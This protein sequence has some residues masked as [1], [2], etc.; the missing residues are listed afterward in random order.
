ML[1]ILDWINSNFWN[2]N[3]RVPFI[4]DGLIST[5]IVDSSQIN[6]RNVLSGVNILEVGCGGGILTEAL[7]KLNA[8]IVALEPSQKLID[9]ATKHLQDTNFQN[10]KIQY[11]CETVESH[12]ESNKDKYDAVV[13]SEVLEHI[14]D[15]KS[16]LKSS[17]E[18]LKP[19]GSVFITTI[20]KT[21]ASWLGAIIAAEQILKIV[22]AGT[23]D[24]NQF[25]SPEEVDKLLKEF[26]CSTVLVHGI[27]Y[28]FWKN[29]C[30]WTQRTDINYAL[31]AVKE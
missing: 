26:N 5:G 6:K 2:F 1:I 30:S 22:P 13:I 29:T 17:I 18:S 27:K 15:Q 25:I 3:F 4:R 8:N 19:G 11:L 7:A 20:N 10:H 28:E 16:F 14:K 21:Q 9:T 12:A 23:H 31:Q 24:W